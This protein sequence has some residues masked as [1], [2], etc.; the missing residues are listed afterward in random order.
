MP[1]RSRLRPLGGLLLAA[2]VSGLLMACEDVSGRP[3]APLTR[4]TLSSI[5][6]P[7]TSEGHLELMRVDV[8]V[9]DEAGV[10]VRFGADGV[11][12]RGGAHGL[13]TI[14]PGQASVAASL[15]PGAS[16]EF[17]AAAFDAAGNQLAYGVKANHVPAGQDLA[18]V[19][20]LETILGA[21]MLTPRLPTRQLMP[22]Q[23]L[24]LM[25][26]A[27]PPGRPGLKVPT[28]DYRASYSVINGT[29]IASSDRG[30]RVRAGQRIGGDLVIYGN[31]EGLVLAADTV[32]A[33]A[34]TA[35][36]R[37]PFSSTLSIDL[38]PPNITR[39]EYDPG[40]RSLA[41]V[42]DDDCG[43]ARVD[44]YDGPVL[45][46]STAMAAAGG[47]S[48]VVFGGGTGFTARLALPPG[49]YSLTLLAFDRSG[50]QATA[51]LDVTI[52]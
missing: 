44:V 14:P 40:T 5:G 7:L 50:N 43:V 24:D 32:A 1:P 38:E 23:E 42:V 8:R 9:L 22:G 33:G 25:L 48:E 11:A 36:L 19:L 6:G 29:I 21:A 45:L 51:E 31:L 49:D 3:S 28:S 17:N 52:H 26:S 30:L 13:I 12:N 39:L 41:G 18:V 20:E 16:Y 4:V 2:L 15:P 35:D 27:S 46:A 10:A 37:L 47:P 34:V